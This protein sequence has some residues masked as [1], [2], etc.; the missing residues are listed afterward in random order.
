VTPAPNQYDPKQTEVGK[1]HDMTTLNGV[2]EMKSAAFSS[3]S[4]Q[5]PQPH[6]EKNP[7]PGQYDPNFESV[8]PSAPDLVPKTGRDTS[9][10]V[11]KLMSARYAA[12]GPGVGPGTY[13]PLVQ[14]DG[15]LDTLSARVERRADFGAWGW[16]ASFISDSIRSFFSSIFPERPSTSTDAVTI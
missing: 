8:E 13:D 3:E 10:V 6:N 16:S 12:T 11:G 2:E 4:V 1:E 15:T 5:R 7:G 9:V 14:K